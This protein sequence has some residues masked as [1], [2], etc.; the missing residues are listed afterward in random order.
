[1]PDSI[2]S[3][4]DYQRLFP[5]KFALD[6]ESQKLDQLQAQQDSK[7][8]RIR[9][10]RENLDNTDSY[11]VDAFNAE[12]GAYKASRPYIKLRTDNYNTRVDAFNQELQR[13]G[14]L[15]KTEPATTVSP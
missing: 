6:A 8:N 11:A 1:M 10:D 7:A 14:T 3:D 12:V 9:Q 2:V 13:V 4:A 5:I 15:I